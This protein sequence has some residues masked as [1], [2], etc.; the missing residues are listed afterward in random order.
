MRL[1]LEVIH[2]RDIRFGEKTTVADGV[3]TI[4][5]AEL[6]ALLREDRRLGDVEIELARPGESCRI[7]KVLDVIEPRAKTSE[8]DADFPGAVGPCKIAGQGRT[9]V[10]RGA[11]VVISDFRE[12]R[13]ISTSSDPNGEIIDMSG[14]GAEIGAFGKTHNCVLL[15]TAGKGVSPRDYM[16]GLKTAGLKT[17]AYLARA[18]KG[19]PPDETEV[20][21]LPPLTEKGPEPETLPTV[22]YIFQIQ[23]LQFEPIQGEPVLYGQNVHGMVPTLI[24]PNEVLDGALTSALPCLN[25]QTYYVQNHPIIRE[26]Y[27][28]NRKEIRFGGVII[29]LAQN[30]L[31]DM[32]RDA[33]MAAN[34]A[35]NIVGADGAVLTKTGGGAPELALA[36]TA[37]CCE[38]LGIKTAIAMLHMGA[39]IKDVK[40]GAVTI[41]NLPEVD[42]IVSMGFPFME[43]KL[44]AVGR[45]I[46]R[47]GPEGSIDGELVRVIRWIK[48]SQCQLGSS[49]LRAVRH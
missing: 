17:A 12:I 39:D 4:H 16:A 13:E 20:Y 41:F 44:P 22:V 29:M 32:D 14:P 18:G 48:G 11:A 49:K 21:D 19:C 23:T 2:I 36:K 33:H 45:V 27:R 15:A 3:L 10:L 1:E 30:N 35:K 34:L 25:V 47:P 7:L 43:L 42:A 6:L 31:S 8:G 5:R 9:C 37:Q 38:R 24:H 46:G 40:Y 28:R 26:M